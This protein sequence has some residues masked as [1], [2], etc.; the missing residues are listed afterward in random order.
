MKWEILEGISHSKHRHCLWN[1]HCS[2]SVYFTWGHDTKCISHCG[3]QVSESESHWGKKT[4]WQVGLIFRGTGQGKPFREVAVWV[5]TYMKWDSPVFQ[6]ELCKGTL[7]KV[8]LQVWSQQEGPRGW[9]WWASRKLG[10]RGDWLTEEARNQGGKL[11]PSHGLQGPIW[12]TT[13]CPNLWLHLSPSVPDP[14]TLASLGPRTHTQYRPQHLCT[15]YL[16]A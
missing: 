11:K 16:T 12:H 3:W 15:A 14:A 4:E 9:N 2:S 5:E 8:G 10:G 1:F 13:P 6:T 7:G